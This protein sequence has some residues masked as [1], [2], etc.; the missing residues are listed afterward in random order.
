MMRRATWLAAGAV[1]GVVG[2]RRLDRAAKSLT[3]PRA[4]T[5]RHAA[6]AAGWMTRRVRLSLSAERRSRGGLATFARDVRVGIDEYLDTHQANID[7]QYPRSGN[8][9]VDQRTARPLPLPGIALGRGRTAAA[10]SGLDT[11]KTTKDGS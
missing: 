7:R 10:R 8:T 3:G 11:N 6:A 1:L 5:G 4:G 2:Y 9:L